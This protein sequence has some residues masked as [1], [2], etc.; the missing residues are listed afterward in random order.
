MPLSTKFPI[1]LFASVYKI[2]LSCTLYET[3][4]DKRRFI[5]NRK[6]EYAFNIF[7]S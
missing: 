6:S 2:K 3:R 7:D 1:N 5:V 4:L